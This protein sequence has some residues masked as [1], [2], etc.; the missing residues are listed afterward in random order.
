V[1]LVIEAKAK[2][3]GHEDTDDGIVYSEKLKVVDLF[4]L[5]RDQGSRLLSTLRSLHRSGEDA[6][7]G[8]A[9]I[10][11]LGEVG[12][13]D[14]SGV[15][16]TPAEIAELRGDPIRTILAPELT[17]AVIVYADGARDLWPDDYPKDAPRPRVGEE[18]LSGDDMVAV[19]QLLHHETG[20]ALD[21]PPAQQ[22]LEPDELDPAEADDLDDDDDGD[23]WETTVVRALDGRPP[24]AAVPP[25]PDEPDPYASDLGADAEGWDDDAPELDPAGAAIERRLPTA[26][27]FAFVDCQIPEL[28]DKLQTVTDLDHA[29]RLRNAE[30]QGRGRGLVARN[31]AMKWIDAR[32]AVLEMEGR[33]DG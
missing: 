25:L 28:R 15:V 20:E 7:K 21:E 22:A 3:A 13:T 12:Y 16:L 19:T 17:P 31:G 26:H 32:V 11:E 4:E 18:Y 33:S 30:K 2:N 9:P 14:G 1:I 5:D 10:P 8:R 29:H 23:G 6:A 24:L 27:D